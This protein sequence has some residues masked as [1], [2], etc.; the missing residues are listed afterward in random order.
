MAQLAIIKQMSRQV[1]R[2]SGVDHQ[3]EEQAG[4]AR[5][6][7]DHQADQQAGFEQLRWR[8]SGR[9]AGRCRAAQLSIIKQMSRQVSRGSAGH[10]QAE[11]QAGVA[12]LNWRISSR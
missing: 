1:S 10:S 9:R 5:S 4:V 3:V 12:G 7:C 2:G 6:G 11:E 8:L